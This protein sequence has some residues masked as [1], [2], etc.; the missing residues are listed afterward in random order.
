MCTS[1]LLFVESSKTFQNK[2]LEKKRTELSK[3]TK[4]DRRI[5]RGRAD[6]KKISVGHCI[7]FYL[8]FVKN[9]VRLDN[10]IPVF[11]DEERVFRSLSDVLRSNS[12][13]G[14]R[15]TVTL[16]QMNGCA[17]DSWQECVREKHRWNIL[18]N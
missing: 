13:H 12:S 2:I 10:F 8:V 5:S 1:L 14:V 16:E 11:I 4:R 9:W 3:Q 18:F 6:V 15:W 17:D 7:L